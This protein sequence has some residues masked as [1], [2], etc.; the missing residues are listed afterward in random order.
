MP[1]SQ[2]NKFSCKKGIHHRAKGSQTLSQNTRISERQALR[3]FKN[4]ESGV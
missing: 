4:T 3:V 1:K 2:G